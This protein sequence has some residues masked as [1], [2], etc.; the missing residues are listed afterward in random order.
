MSK[1]TLF[2]EDWLKLQQKYWE[3]LT[4]MSQ[5]AMGM[6][7]PKQSPWEAAMEQWWRAVSPAASNPAQDFMQRMMD[8]GKNF[9]AMAEQFTKPLAGA[10]TA[11]DGWEMLN[12]TLE[13]M[14]NAFTGALG[15][16]DESVRRMMGF[17]EMP[18]DNWQRMM[19][20]MSPV[21]GDFLRNMP[22]DQ[23]KDS[24]NRML[25]APGLGYTREEQASYQDLIRRN[26]DYQRAMQEYAG[27][28]NKLGMK[29]VERMREFVQSRAEKGESI[30]SARSLY[31]SWISCCEAVYADEVGTPEY[32]R[33]HGQLVNAQ[34]A[35]KKR[36]SVMVDE[37][38]G[39]MNMPTRSELRTL[40]DRLQETRR[41]NKQLRRDLDMIKRRIAHVPAGDAPSASAAATPSG[42][43]AAK[44]KAAPRK[45]A[46]AKTI[47][48]PSST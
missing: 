5:K 6:S 41:E 40:Q 37:T 34:M 10:D 28:F 27:F 33:I 25:S 9:F 16:G 21:P 12:K 7:A 20:S 44:K 4:E 2:N 42:A 36:M 15:D 32:A 38:L 24:M 48:K 1:Q 31:D 8:Q 46:V 14:Q 45:K 18:L 17:W 35:L 43:D 13:Q 11:S 39:T 30:D 26:L 3:G 19:S 22:H 29:S 47:A 23:V